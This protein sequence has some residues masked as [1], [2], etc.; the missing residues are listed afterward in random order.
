MKGVVFFETS[1]GFHH[2]HLVVRRPTTASLFHFILN[3]RFLF[4][5]HPE[6]CLRHLHPRPVALRGAMKVLRIGPTEADLDR[7]MNYVAKGL[8]V[9]TDRCDWKFLDELSPRQV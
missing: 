9:A 1:G 4:Q 5:P 3:A 2:A 7:V 8:E 6:V